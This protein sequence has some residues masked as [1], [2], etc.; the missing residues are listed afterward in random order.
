[1]AQDILAALIFEGRSGYTKE[2]LLGLPKRDG[3]ASDVTSNVLNYLIQMIYRS[4]LKL[5]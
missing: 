2:P 3:S 1:M 5:R 4:A